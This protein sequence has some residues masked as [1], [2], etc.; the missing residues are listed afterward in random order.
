MDYLGAYGRI[1]LFLEDLNQVLG[2]LRSSTPGPCANFNSVGF[3][4]NSCK[5]QTHRSRVWKQNHRGNERRK[6][7]DGPHSPRH[8]CP[9]KRTG[10]YSNPNA[11][12][13]RLP[14]RQLPT[15]VVHSQRERRY[16]G[17]MG[18]PTGQLRS[19][20]QQLEDF[21]LHSKRDVD[22]VGQPQG[23]YLRL[24]WD[25]PVEF[26]IESEDV[27][28][29]LIDA[30]YYGQHEEFLE[31]GNDHCCDMAIDENDQG[32]TELEDLDVPA[33]TIPVNYGSAQPPTDDTQDPSELGELH[34]RNESDSDTRSDL[35]VDVDPAK[36]NEP[37]SHSSSASITLPDLELV[38]SID[39]G[40]G[41]THFPDPL[42]SDD[43]PDHSELLDQQ[44][45]HGHDDNPDS[46]HH[47]DPDEYTSD[48][49][50]DFLD[51]QSHHEPGA[52]YYDDGAHDDPGDAY[53]DDG[54]DV[55]PG[56]DYHDDDYHD[57]YYDDGG[58]FNY[59]D[60]DY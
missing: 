54:G 41:T 35:G 40:H 55:D 47:T 52:D 60:D 34:L 21:H 2:S 24:G 30:S 53:Y 15:N 27:N 11:C 22:Q 16:P 51:Q 17:G 39:D 7:R 58:D 3:R 29:I 13:V 43:N 46:H 19:D 48:H 38:P 28:R 1:Q 5:R 50:G 36:Y 14:P 56:D 32:A 8:S 45:D 31:L 37:C 9:T 59:Y 42:Q 49:A 23:D 26:A 44:E 4:Q 12:V 20:P 25:A 10:T 18:P 33:V 57:D 6:P